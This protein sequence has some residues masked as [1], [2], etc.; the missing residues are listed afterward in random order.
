MGPPTSPAFDHTQ[1]GSKGKSNRTLPEP[2]LL[3][4][5]KP[6]LQA[7]NQFLSTSCPWAFGRTLTKISY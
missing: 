6:K 4:T 2:D 7:R 1:G 5:A 3:H